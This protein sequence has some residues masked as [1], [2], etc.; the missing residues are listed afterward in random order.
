LRV[1]VNGEPHEL[2]DTISLTELLARLKLPADRIAVELNK[3]VVRRT[4]WDT[5][6]LHDDDRVE[7]VHFV[8]GGQE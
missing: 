4:E 8:G 5:V 7:A 2:P 3:S 1:Y 6:H